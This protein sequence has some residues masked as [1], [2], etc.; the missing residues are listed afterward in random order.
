[1]SKLQ[2]IKTHCKC[3]LCSYTATQKLVFCAAWI[4]HRNNPA[5]RRQGKW[6]KRTVRRAVIWNHSSDLLGSS[7][8]VL[9]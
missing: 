8:R 4:P 1:M 3:N 2:Q 7:K 5:G 9:V 6:S